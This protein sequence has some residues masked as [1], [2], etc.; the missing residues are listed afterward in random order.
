MVMVFG[1]KTA[2][3]LSKYY[4][5]FFLEEQLKLLSLDGVRF[6]EYASTSYHDYIRSIPYSGK[7][8]HGANFHGFRG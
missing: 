6:F 8:S 7:F 4:C 5:T 1:F 2:G 3:H